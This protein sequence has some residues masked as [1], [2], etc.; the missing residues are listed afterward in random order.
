MEDVC[1]LT[2]CVLID[3][4]IT[5]SYTHLDV[6]KRQGGWQK[7]LLLFRFI[8]TKLQHLLSSTRPI[9]VQYKTLLYIININIYFI[10]IFSCIGHLRTTCQFQFFTLCSF[11]FSNILSSSHCVSSSCL[12]STLNLRFYL[13]YP[14]LP[15]FSTLLPEK[16]LFQLLL[17]RVCVCVC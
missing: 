10:S 4:L 6:Y 1:I 2:R 14:G 16:L 8:R 11:L 3:S 9:A 17:L 7:L 13:S 15:P 12:Q 5:A